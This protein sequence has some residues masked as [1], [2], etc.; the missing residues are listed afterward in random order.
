MKIKCF[1]SAE[2]VVK[3]LSADFHEMIL[4]LAS[5]KETICIAVSGGTTPEMF[6]NDLAD[7]HDITGKTFPWEKVHMFWVDER[8]VPPDNAQSNYG[9]VHRK[10]LSRLNPCRIN[11]HRIKG[12]AEPYR[13]AERYSKEI[14]KYVK[15]E[16]E[17][18]VF[19]WIMLGVGE[20]GHTAS[21][22]PDRPDLLH[23]PAIC[24][25]VKHPA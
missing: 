19:D 16:N 18:P 1:Q 22:F 5:T 23:S 8:C 15:R 21:L 24:E 2:E 6:F 14:L 25:A 13:E 17:F 11:I 4:D 3:Q 9:M 12:E 10:F 20:D 7:T